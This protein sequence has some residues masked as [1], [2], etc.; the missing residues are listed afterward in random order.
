MKLKTNL[1]QPKNFNRSQYELEEFLIICAFVAGKNSKLQYNKVELL[2]DIL[3]NELTP[4]ESLRKLNEDEIMSILKQIKS[5]QYSRLCKC[6]YDL[7]RSCLDLRTCSTEALESI[8]GIGMKTSRFFITYSR[9]NSNYAILDTHILA[10]MRKFDETIP[11]ATPNNKKQYLALEK[12]FLEK[13]AEKNLK[14]HELDIQLW[15]ERQKSWQV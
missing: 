7:S 14:P 6:L 5:G 12:I 15:L 13:C 1:T 10:W 2:F 3:G 11:R 9:E 8:F 4:F